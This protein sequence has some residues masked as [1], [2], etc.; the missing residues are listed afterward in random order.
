MY[1][2]LALLSALLLVGVSAAKADT[3]ENLSFAGTTTCRVNINQECL[4]TG[5]NGAITGNY[6]L[7]I[8]DEK[9]VGAWSFTTIYGSISSTDNLPFAG[10]GP[11]TVSGVLY[12]E[13]GFQIT[14]L[15]TI[16]LFFA[17][18]DPDEV[19]AL[20]GPVGLS[21]MCQN[22]PGMSNSCS[23]DLNI[24]GS[25]TLSSTVVTPEP[26]PFALTAT[27]LLALAFVARKQLV[28]GVL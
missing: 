18:S 23:P 24:S 6:T 9:I 11:V 20:A 17:A 2:R 14:P 26:S 21:G 5:G 3:L 19:G 7:D 4:P 16:Y 8:T 25:T 10:A 12:N 1:A 13:A 22:I 15:E 28:D 27:A